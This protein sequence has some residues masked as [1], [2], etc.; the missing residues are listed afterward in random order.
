MQGLRT[1]TVSLYTP[2]QHILQQ[3]HSSFSYAASLH[4]LFSPVFFLILF[5]FFFFLSLLNLSLPPFLSVNFNY[6]SLFRHHAPFHSRRDFS[7]L[8]LRLHTLWLLMIFMIYWCSLSK[9]QAP[10]WSLHQCF[11]KS[12]CWL[13]FYQLDT[14]QSHLGRKLLSRKKNCLPEIGLYASLD[15][16]D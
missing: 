2:A 13:A 14:N 16:L 8:S 7:L 1:V 9:L 6:T 11:I 12:L 5:S 4:C 15:F 10:H 3:Q